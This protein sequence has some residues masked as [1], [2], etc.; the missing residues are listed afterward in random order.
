V[1]RRTRLAA[2]RR[3]VGLT[4][5]SLAEQLEVDRVTVTRWE[6]GDTAPQPWQ[7]PKLARLLRITVDELDGLLSGEAKAIDFASLAELHEQLGLLNDDYDRIPSALLLAAAGQCH[8]EAIRHRREAHALRVRR[9]AWAVEAESAILMGQLVWDASQ[10]QDHATPQTYFDAAVTAAARAGDTVLEAHAMLRKSFV[11]LYGLR[12]PEVGLR[13]AYKAS[14]ISRRV[15]EVL[16][17]QALLHVAEA[18]AMTRDISACETALSSADDAFSRVEVTDA[19]YEQYSPNQLP[20]LAGSCYLSLGRPRK[21]E[22]LLGPLAAA[23]GRTKKSTGIVLGNLALAYLRQ[24]K[25]DEA[26]ATL[27]DAV[28]FVALSR[29]GGGL[30]VVFAAGRELRPWLK[31]PAVQEVNDWLLGLMTTP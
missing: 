10:R 22:A 25:L 2:R 3:L 19:A 18:Y 5:E 17:G 26:T 4:Q 31:K 14:Q 6:S 28:D 12:Q 9:Q 15:S 20:R 30:N 13:L 21:A 23:T 24:R 7:R 11:A 27:H 1:A 29:G 16:A 8:Q